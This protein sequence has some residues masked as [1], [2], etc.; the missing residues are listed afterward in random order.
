MKN[1]GM[2]MKQAQQMQAKMAAFQDSLGDLHMEGSAGGGKVTVVVNGKHELVSV[3]FDPEVV[4]ANDTELLEDLVTAA[5]HEAQ[6]K[7]EEYLK[8]EMTKLT[9]GVPLPF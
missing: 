4:A 7:V 6:A 2:L 3:K 9:G 1:M 8:V 5:F